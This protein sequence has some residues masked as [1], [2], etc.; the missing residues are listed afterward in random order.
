MM[1]KGDPYI[2][3]FSALPEV[4]VLSCICHN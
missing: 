2:K 1:H 4:R 3:V